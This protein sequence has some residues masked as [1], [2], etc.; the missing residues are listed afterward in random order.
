MKRTA[1]RR[2][3]NWFETC[4]AAIG[5][6]I[7]LIWAVDMLESMILTF[8][9]KS[10][11][12]TAERD[13]AP[14]PPAP[15]AAT[16]RHASTASPMT[17]RLD[18]NIRS[19]FSRLRSTTDAVALFPAELSLG[20][21]YMTEPA[22]AGRDRVWRFFGRSGISVRMPATPPSSRE[23]VAPTGPKLDYLERLR[24]LQALT[25]VALAHLQLDP[26]LDALLERTRELLGADTCAVLMLDE[27]RKE[28]VARAAV[29]L[30]EEV[31]QG[32]RIPVGRG[33]A[34]AVAASRRPVILDDVDHADVLNPI[35]R[36]KGIKSMLGVPLLVGGDPIGVLHVGTLVPRRFD[37]EDVELLQIAADRAAVAIDHARL[38][39]AE[40]RARERI[41]R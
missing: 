10:G 28:L 15:P 34:G 3:P 8:G 19:P 4:A 2:V 30:E 32:V 16:S 39:E 33:F 29:G 5:S 36:E 35:L 6:T 18:T 37:D 12:A 17:R 31:E 7:A 20:E 26:L 13:A 24:R 27:D 22:P 14:A 21:E 40:R 25:D 38:Y 9:P 1:S 23:S 11:V 41:E